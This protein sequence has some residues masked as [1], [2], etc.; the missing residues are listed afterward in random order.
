VEKYPDVPRD[1]RPNGFLNLFVST[2]QTEPFAVLDMNDEEQAADFQTFLGENTDLSNQAN[3]SFRIMFA[4]ACASLA[5]T[6]SR[7]LFLFSR[8]LSQDPTG[9]GTTTAEPEG[10]SVCVYVCLYHAGVL[11]AC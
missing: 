6:V 10:V 3:V 11:L 1:G 9:A 4:S 7:V 8:A 5:L 2:G